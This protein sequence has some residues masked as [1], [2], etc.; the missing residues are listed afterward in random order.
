MDILF[1]MFLVFWIGYAAGRV[2]AR[3]DYWCSRYDIERNQKD[4]NP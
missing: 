2:H 1:D 4:P 3:I